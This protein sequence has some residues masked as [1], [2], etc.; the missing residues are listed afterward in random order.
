MRVASGIGQPDREIAKGSL[1]LLPF[2]GAC[3]E[4]AGPE[5]VRGS[6]GYRLSLML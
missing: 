4:S 6:L 2:A 1:T 5:S 3:S